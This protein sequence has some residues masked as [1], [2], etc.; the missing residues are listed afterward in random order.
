MTKKSKEKIHPNLVSL[1]KKNWGNLNLGSETWLHQS[2]N[3][4]N[5]SKAE[6]SKSIELS[7]EIQNLSKQNNQK[8]IKSEIGL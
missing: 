2:E 6:H 4:K 3:Q 8:S 5:L 7:S 1:T